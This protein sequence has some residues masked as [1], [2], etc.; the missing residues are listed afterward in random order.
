MGKQKSM[1]CVK[2]I[3][4]L[5]VARPPAKARRNARPRPDPDQSGGRRCAA[6]SQYTLGLALASRGSLSSARLRHSTCRR[7]LAL[8][9][10]AL[11]Y[12]H[13]TSPRHSM[14]YTPSVCSRPAASLQPSATLASTR[15]TSTDSHSHALKP[16]L[17]SLCSLSHT[18]M[19]FLHAFCDSR[20][21]S[22]GAYFFGSHPGGSL[23]ELTSGSRRR[24]DALLFSG[25][26]ARHVS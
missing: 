7:R 21:T 23:A 12:V 8:A 18:I 17:S 2:Y 24:N 10:T 22:H 25:G 3:L 14:Q 4:P 6:A 15:L 11:L 5:R 19:R 16:L 26:C 9:R 20:P 13:D 1:S